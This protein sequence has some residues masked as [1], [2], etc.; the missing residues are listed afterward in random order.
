MPC[1]PPRCVTGLAVVDTEHYWS[2]F[3]HVVILALIQ[4]GGFGIMTLATL[5]AIL[6]TG[7]VGLSQALLAKSESQAV[8]LGAGTPLTPPRPWAR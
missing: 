4:V 5:A 2:T 6:T 1:L 3:G 7:R 8:T